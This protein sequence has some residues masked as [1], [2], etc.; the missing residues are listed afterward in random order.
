[1]KLPD[2][3]KPQFCCSKDA[4][5]YILQFACVRNGMV[6]ASNG[7]SAV[8]ALTEEDE[9][10]EDEV[11]EALIPVEALKVATKK[12]TQ[13]AIFCQGLVTLLKDHWV[14]VKDNLEMIRT[15]R[16]GDEV[17]KFPNFSKICPQDLTGYMPISFNA[18]MLWEVAQAL[19]TEQITLW[20]LHNNVHTDNVMLVQS[21][22]HKDRLGMLM[23]LRD[24]RPELQTNRAYQRQQA[25]TP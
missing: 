24:Q 2:K 8:M 22:T 1:M 5:R 7:R 18:K 17:E 15:I 23:P 25:A 3:L 6:Y 4:T 11:S 14:K 9:F 10:K 13:G 12:R 21:T 19:G 16:A 20:H